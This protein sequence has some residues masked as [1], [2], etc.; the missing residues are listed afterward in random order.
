VRV[1]I[2]RLSSLGDVVCCL[3]AAVAMK[4]R[5]PECRISWVCDSRFAA[6]PR[7]CAVVDE[8]VEASPGVSPRT[9]PRFDEPFDVALDLQGL[10][11]SGLTVARSHAK[12][13]LGYH[14][15][16][17]GSWLFSQ[18]VVPDETSW[19]VVDQYADVARAA[20]GEMDRAEFA[21]TPDSDTLTSVRTKLFAGRQPETLVAIN[22]GAA[23][24]T[25]RWPPESC[26][27]LI[28]LLAT[29]GHTSV[30]IGGPSA[31]DLALAESIAELCPS[32]PLLATGKTT[33]EELVAL[34]SLCDV[35]VGGDTGSTHIMAALGRP[36]V[37]LYSITR[38]KRS[39]PYGQIDRCH[40]DPRGLDK[41]APEAVCDTVLE[42][43]A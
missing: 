12:L 33:L 15:Q 24:A 37:G 28:D 35:H 16:R 22:P 3:P 11:K 25:K 30:L 23:W 4:K 27:S 14:W 8:T 41:I 40:H 1:L 42:A 43:L 32:K 9:W 13:K 34:L 39:C 10:L 20:G 17:E 5:Y 36:A 29:R 38:P 2:S 19:H 7:M 18:R 6:I 31:S 21:L 26:A